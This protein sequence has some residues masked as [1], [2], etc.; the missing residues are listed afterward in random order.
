MLAIQGT[1]VLKTLADALLFAGEGMLGAQSPPALKMKNARAGATAKGIGYVVGARGDAHVRNGAG[2]PSRSS[3]RDLLSSFPSAIY[4]IA[5]FLADHY[6]RRVRIA[7]G[8]S[9]EDGCV[10]D[11]QTE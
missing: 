2:D 7:R 5:R 10:C 11:S 8:E 1:G 9:R 6:R 4:Q 3:K